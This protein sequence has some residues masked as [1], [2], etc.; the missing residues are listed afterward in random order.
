MSTGDDVTPYELFGGHEFFE[1]L[2]QAFYSRVANDDVLRPMYPDEDLTEAQWR[3]RAFLEQYWGGPK[4]YGERR[5]H[6]KLRMRHMPFHVDSIARD[7]WLT[8][9]KAAVD[10]Q[11]M[12]PELEKELWQYLVSAAFAMQ[13][14]PDDAHPHPIAQIDEQPGGSAHA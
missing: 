7:R 5:G 2:I 13:N 9:M 3:L 10:E 6:P 14:V 1:S 12:P 4:T 8:H 11:H